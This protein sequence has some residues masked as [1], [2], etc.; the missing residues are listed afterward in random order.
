MLVL[1]WRSQMRKENPFLV[2]LLLLFAT[3][4]YAETL[5]GHV[6]KVADG[7]TLTILDASTVQHKIRIS[8]IDAP[9]RNQ[10]FGAASK[11]QM[12]ELAFGKEA[13]VIC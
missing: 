7:D 4:V 3:S 12:S 11:K 1:G 2:I 8:G 9:E 13:E 10:P 6:V 5:T